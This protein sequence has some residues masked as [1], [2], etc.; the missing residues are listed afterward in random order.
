MGWMPT[1]FEWKQQGDCGFGLMFARKGNTEGHGN[2]FW[3]CLDDL[4]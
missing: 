2:L 3:C 4:V 1:L